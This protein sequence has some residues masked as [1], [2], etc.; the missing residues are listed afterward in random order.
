MLQPVITIES[1]QGPMDLLLHLIKEK[2]IDI[3]DLNLNDVTNQYV[4]FINEELIKNIDLVSEYLPIAAYL[5]ELQSKQLLPKQELVVDS[6]YENEVNRQKLI[7]RLLEYKK[8][9][10]ISNYFKEQAVYRT[11]LLTKAPSDL[12]TY[13]VD[14]ITPILV[15]NNVNKLTQ[16][17]LNLFN[18]LQNENKLP[19][20]LALNLISAEDRAKEIKQLLKKNPKQH[21]TLEQLFFTK[22]LTLHYFIITFIAILDLANHQMLHIIQTN[23]FTEITVIYRGEKN[24]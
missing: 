6:A 14:E 4:H 23:T 8:F 15:K 7:A 10:E 3:L 21:F 2:N 18:R 5:L 24:E 19:V 16:A 20:N 9:K 12:K 22:T 13:L 11:Q 17:M 1:F